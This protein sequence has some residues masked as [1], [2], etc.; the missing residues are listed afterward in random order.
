MRSGSHASRATAPAGRGAASGELATG[1][2][3]ARGGRT[4]STPAGRCDQTVTKAPMLA[5]PTAAATRT[6][7]RLADNPDSIRDSTVGDGPARL[8]AVA[9][10]DSRSDA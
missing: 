1:A 8:M 4:G 5:K 9:I 10:A 3:S 7:Q 2:T 6:P